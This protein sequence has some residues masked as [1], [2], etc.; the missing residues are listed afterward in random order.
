M[1]EE[2]KQYVI[3]RVHRALAE[4]PR[5]NVLDV[6]VTLAGGRVFLT[7]DVATQARKDA[8][9]EVVRELLPDH[10]VCNETTVVSYAPATEPE[11]IS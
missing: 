10:E 8:I 1:A 2:P 7:G 4:D 9:S 11:D 5:A 3:E 6:E